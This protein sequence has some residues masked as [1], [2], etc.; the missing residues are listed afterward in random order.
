MKAKLT[1]S[2]SVGPESVPQEEDS[3]AKTVQR[4]RRLAG[5]YHWDWGVPDVPAGN[6]TSTGDSGAYLALYGVNRKG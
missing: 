2:D 1:D 6:V 3:R 4:L 5:G